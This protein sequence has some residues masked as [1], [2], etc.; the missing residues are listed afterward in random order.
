MMIASEF[1]QKNFD[2]QRPSDTELHGCIRELIH[3]F[4]GSKKQIPFLF[5]FV[6]YHIMLVNSSFKW[7]I[8]KDG[9]NWEDHH[10]KFS[11]GE[12]IAKHEE[13]V[14]KNMQTGVLYRPVDP[15]F[16]AVDML[17]V[18]ENEP[19]QRVYFGIQVTFAEAHAKS[20]TVYKKLYDR[21]GLNQKDKLK[22]CIITNPYHAETYA[23][24]KKDQFFKPQLK[25]EDNFLYDIEFATISAKEFD[26]V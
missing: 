26:K 7:N 20:K 17:W 8:C 18:E 22:I 9:R 6:V 11:S 13:E 24:L 21:L 10:L 4:R 1:V 3:M 5:E 25:P 14:L 23:K 15:Q 2:E 12:V 19:G 16:P